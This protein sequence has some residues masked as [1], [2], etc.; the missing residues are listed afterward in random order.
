MLP[1]IA[2]RLPHLPAHHDSHGFVRL[3]RLG[4]GTR[5]KKAPPR[6]GSSPRYRSL[7]VEEGEEVAVRASGELGDAPE[8]LLVLEGIP[9][10]G[11]EGVEGRLLHLLERC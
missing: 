7:M 6:A 8:A 2:R 11:V 3:L 4:L 5:N 10:A 9:A 1:R